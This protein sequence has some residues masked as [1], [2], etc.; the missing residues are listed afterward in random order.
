MEVR[1]A[2][3]AVLDQEGREDRPFV[4]EE[5]HRDPLCPEV[6]GHQDAAEDRHCFRRL[7][8]EVQEGLTEKAGEG[9]SGEKADRLQVCGVPDGLGIREGAT[10]P[11][12]F[13]RNSTERGKCKCTWAGDR[14]PEEERPAAGSDR[15]W[16]RFETEAEEE[17]QRGDGT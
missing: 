8:Q 15:F 7:H 11:L 10:A 6:E 9:Q 12:A 13:H 2:E 3:A 1:Q 5:G 17:D 4:A 14:R 16:E